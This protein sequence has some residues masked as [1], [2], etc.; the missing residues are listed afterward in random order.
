MMECEHIVHPQGCECLSPESGLEN[1]VVLSVTHHSA[2]SMADF[3]S[4]VISEST[5]AQVLKELKE[6]LAVDELVYISTCNRVSFILMSQRRADVLLKILFSWFMSQQSET[7][8]PPLE[9]WIQLQGRSALE[10]LLLVA[11]SLDS[12]VVGERQILGQFKQ[13]FVNAREQDLSGPQT[14]FLY[15]QILSVAKR[16]YTETSLSEGSLSM[17]S[18]TG[19]HLTAFCEKHPKLQ[20]VLVGVSPMIEK[21][22][23]HLSQYPGVSLLFV[24]RTQERSDALKRQYHGASMSLSDFVTHPPP[25]NLL[26]TSTSAPHHL[27]GCSDFDWVNASNELL[28][29]DLAI[30]QDVD[31]Q[32]AELDGVQLMNVDSLRAQAKVH[33]EQRAEAIHDARAILKQGTESIIGRWRVRGVNSAIRAIRERYEQ[34]SLGQLAKL[35][36]KDLAHLPV[37]DKERLSDWVRMMSERWAAVHALGVKQMAR[38]CCA[39]AVMSYLDGVGIEQVNE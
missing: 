35:L 38:E 15:E 30:P 26:V 4:L 36:K 11:S 18:L 33:R 25:F 34:E 28:I 10:H 3:S 20:A 21:I 5:Q 39:K 23:A 32:V 27:F 13:A 8:P 2:D 16:V 24:N 31:P 14:Q 7:P 19:T 37:Q 9:Q 29:I 1:F 12:M 17:A 6:I 22:S